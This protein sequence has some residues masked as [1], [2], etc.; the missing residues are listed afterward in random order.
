MKLN[1]NTDKEF[2]LSSWA[3]NN[4]TTMYVL[5][6]LFFF[7]G[8]SAFFNMPRENFPEVNETKIYI[9]TI[10]PGNTAEDIEKLVTDPLEDKLKTVSNLVE[11]TSSSQEDYSMLV[12]EFD[13]DIT[14][15]QAKQ[16][17]KDDAD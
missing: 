15:E 8:F 9:S 3:I 10:F 17:V 6:L 12:A 16:K 14:V 11:I 7:L 4:R 5:I 1:K 2:V 13:E